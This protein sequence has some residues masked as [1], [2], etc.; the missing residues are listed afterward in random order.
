MNVRDASEYLGI[1]VK[2]LYKWKRQAAHNHGF[3]I[4]QGR[5][6][7]FRFRQ[8]GVLGQGRILF[9]REWLDELRRAM[10]GQF[11]TP[12]QPRCR[13]LSN[14]QARLGVPPRY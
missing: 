3:L 9:E 14:I 4:F 6:V 2:T 5:A 8:T 11:S 10:E 1:A 7:R 13:P 12:Q